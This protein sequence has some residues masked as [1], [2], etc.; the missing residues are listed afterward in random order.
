M[1]EGPRAGG[2]RRGPRHSSSANSASA[3]SPAAA[4]AAVPPPPPPLFNHESDILDRAILEAQRL[5]DN[6][7]RVRGAIGTVGTRY[8][9]ATTRRTSS[10]RQSRAP[11]QADAVDDNLHDAVHMNWEITRQ[12]NGSIDTVLRKLTAAQGKRPTIAIEIPHE[13]PPPSRAAAPDDDLLEKDDPWAGLPLPDDLPEILPQDFDFAAHALVRSGA[14]EPGVEPCVEPG[15]ERSAEKDTEQGIEQSTAP[16]PEQGIGLGIQS[17]TEPAARP[18]EDQPRDGFVSEDRAT[19]VNITTG[20]S[21]PLEDAKEIPTKHEPA[22]PIDIR[23]NPPLVVPRI[24]HEFDGKLL[25]LSPDMEQWLDFSTLLLF[26]RECGANQVGAFKVRLSDQVLKHLGPCGAEEEAVPRPKKSCNGFRSKRL[27]N[28]TFSVTTTNDSRVFRRSDPSPLPLLEAVQH[29]EYLLRKK[30]GLKGVFY[31][32]D[33]PVQTPVERLT[34]GLPPRSAIWPLEG[35]MLR[36]T[37]QEIPGIHWPYG[38]ESASE[39]GAMFALHNEDFN[40]HSVSHLH[41]GRKIWI[42]IPPASAEALEAKMR[43]TDPTI[44]HC[45]QCIRHRSLFVPTTLLDEWDIPYTVVDQRAPEVV[46]TMPRTYHSGFSAGYTLAEASNYADADWTPGGYVA[47]PITCPDFPIDG[48]LMA[49]LGP[50]EVQKKGDAD[51]DDDTTSDATVD[52]G[53]DKPGK[54]PLPRKS[55]MAQA[56]PKGGPRKSSMQSAPLA[57][58]STKKGKAARRDSTKPSTAPGAAPRGNP[59]PDSPLAEALL[60]PRQSAKRRAEAPLEPSSAK[61]QRSKSF[62]SR[63]DVAETPIQM[64]GGHLVRE[65]IRP[66]SHSVE[67]VAS[68]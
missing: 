21:L 65:P 51:D 55:Q 22:S 27:P 45:G 68:C 10:R 12:Q 7:L 42:M 37:K 52:A 15:V 63:L 43:E 13:Q 39:F 28:K 53:M 17:A 44:G 29:Q 23:D 35:D 14:A 62:E 3:L 59:A 34:A 5:V 2:G 25:V 1:A 66:A 9:P 38:Y 50:G 11:S 36:Q 6:L 31:R 18:R 48:A 8:S 60:P 30:Q 57:K 41:R 33:I 58:P 61:I 4:A 47:C 49:F 24:K 19:L 46:V 56:T 16:H 54:I 40:L 32:T 20:H 26:A 64:A 67:P